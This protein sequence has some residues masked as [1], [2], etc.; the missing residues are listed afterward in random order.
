MKPTLPVILT[1]CILALSVTACDDFF[2]SGWGSP[3]EYSADNINVTIS[4]LDRWI[5]RTIGNPPLAKLVSEN[6]SRQ[7][8]DLNHPHRAQFQ[9]AG[10]RMAVESSGLGVAL[11]TNALTILSDMAD[12]D[13]ENM[14]AMLKGVFSGIQ[15]DFR[16]SGGVGAARNITTIAAHDISGNPP[17]FSDVAFVNGSTPSEVGQV[18]LVLT[19]AKLEEENINDMTYWG[20]DLKAFDLEL[21][22]GKVMIVGT[23]DPKAIVLAAY[24]N[25]ILEEDNGRF[26]DNFLT[27][28]IRDAFRNNN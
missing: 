25:L 28:A 18:I 4:N 13:D 20:F 7:V 17:E 10:I 2:S 8:A 26:A 22:G 23:P 19:L 27:V 3:R 6:I 21:S 5:D 15:R 12:T 11:F 14:D 9:R 16:N 1:A 24:L